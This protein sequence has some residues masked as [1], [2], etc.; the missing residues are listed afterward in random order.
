MGG[1]GR[2]ARGR[3]M[4]SRMTSIGERE[5]RC[6]FTRL[7]TVLDERILGIGLRQLLLLLVREVEVVEAED[8]CIQVVFLPQ[9]LSEGR[10][11]CALSTSLDAIETDEERCALVLE[12]MGLVL[13]VS[14]EDEWDAVFGLIVNDG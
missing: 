12:T 10:H 5:G 3:I 6:L 4:A 1:V 8:Q 13:L 7:S 11:Q 9:L 14:L 2:G